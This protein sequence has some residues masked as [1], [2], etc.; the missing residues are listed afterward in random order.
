MTK[1]IL[2]ES[3]ADVVLLEEGILKIKFKGFLKPAQMQKTL[4][5]VSSALA[6]YKTQ[7]ILVNQQAMKVLS[8]EVQEQLLH[9]IKRSDST[10]RRVA[11]INPEDIFAKAGLDKIHHDSHVSD[12]TTRDFNTELEGIR[13]LLQ[14]EV[15]K[16]TH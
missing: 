9:A 11:R 16:P 4:E 14:P 1:Y 12:S 6:V 10:N 3:Y 13:W 15:V 2:E 5:A 7:L 8:K